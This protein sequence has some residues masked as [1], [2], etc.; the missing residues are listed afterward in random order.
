MLTK[1]RINM[2]SLVNNGSGTTSHI[3]DI[4]F[5][6]LKI[7]S[8]YAIT[9]DIQS[10]YTGLLTLDKYTFSFVAS[11]VYTNIPIILTKNR[12]IKIS[13]L[14]VTIRN[15]DYNVSSSANI[16]VRCS[17]YGDCSRVNS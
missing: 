7:G 3:I 6:S 14:Q 9:F 16:F 17:D 2:S 8:R 10:P 4:N 5:S 1:L 11:S 13:I 12:D 15:I